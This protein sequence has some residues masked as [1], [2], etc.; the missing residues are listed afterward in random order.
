[1]MASRSVVGGGKLVE[2]G[3][4]GIGVGAEYRHFQP[5]ADIAAVPFHRQCRNPEQRA[6]GVEILDEPAGVQHM[7]VGPRSTLLDLRLHIPDVRYTL[8]ARILDRQERTMV[9]D[10]KWVEKN[11]GFDPISTPPP[12]DTFSVSRVAKAAV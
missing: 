9:A 11:L 12:S 7:R 2:F 1:M 5:F 10:R 8:P 3:S 6:I 4:D